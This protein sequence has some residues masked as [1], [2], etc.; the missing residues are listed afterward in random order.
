MN[1]HDLSYYLIQAA[2]SLL[3]SATYITYVVKKEGKKFEK[4]RANFNSV[5]FARKNKYD[6]VFYILS[7]LVMLSIKSLIRSYVGIEE[8]TD[9]GLS[10]LSGLIGSIV[11]GG[12]L[13]KTYK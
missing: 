4:K 9:L 12:I 5:K 8:I 10:C 11:I 13:D 2:L 3:G 1:D 6:F 7:G